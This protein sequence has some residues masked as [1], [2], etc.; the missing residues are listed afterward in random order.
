M[1]AEQFRDI[2]DT[3]PEI[4]A[5][6]TEAGLPDQA[7]GY[8]LK[9]GQHATR[10]S[11]NLDAI[12]H[13]DRGLALLDL[14]ANSSER[15]RLEYKFCLALLTP[16]IAAKGYTA[17]ELERIF[18]RALL[19]SEEIGDTEEIFP[20]LY[21]RQVFELVIGRFDRA[22]VHAEEAICSPDATPH[23]SAAFAGRLLG[24]TRLKLFL[25]ETATASE[26]LQQFLTQYDQVPWDIG[27]QVRPG[28]LRRVC[29]LF[30]FV[31]RHLGFVDQARMHSERAIEY[32]RSLGHS[33]TL[34]FALAYGGA[35]FAALCRDLNY[36][37]LTVAELLEIGKA[38]VS[39]SWGAA[40]TGLHGSCWSSA[41][42]RARALPHCRP[43]LGH[44]RRDGRRSGSRPSVPGLRRLMRPTVRSRRGSPRWRWVGRPRPA[45]LTG[46][47]RNC[48]AW[49][50]T[51]CR[52]GRW[53]NMP[54]RKRILL[55]LSPWPECSR[56][57]RWNC[58][59]QRALRGCG[60]TEGGP[61]RRAPCSS[62]SWRGSPRGKIR[63]ICGRRSR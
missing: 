6:H 4:V 38:H 9:A 8:W 32:A 2:A 49:R 58:A 10:L 5:R 18:E 3:Q 56:P 20:A 57:T 30:D 40:A 54:A 15:L 33:N 25:G 31:L 7:V 43:G 1:I 29:L 12:S 47:M 41:D 11:S 16:L 14:I 60:R 62:Q 26:Q 13:F 22:A 37:E 42:R 48:I 34:Q 55:R 27:A 23:P 17:P 19:L 35:Y 45:G 28:P 51:F 36:L 59:P 52:W 53:L 44:L 50:A 63:P 24:A 21:S 61:T 39:P 46:W